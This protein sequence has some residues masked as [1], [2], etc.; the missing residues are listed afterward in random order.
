MTWFTLPPTQ[1]DQ[2]A[3]FLDSR[4]ASAWLAGQPQANA[5]AMLSELLAQLRAFNA[6][7]V[8]PDERFKT[9]TV[10]RNTLSAVS[11]ECQRRYENKPL[12][13]SPAERGLQD[14]VCALWR[15]CAVSYL[16][17]L[18]ACLEGDASISPHA[19]KVAHRA[20]CCLRM[21]QLSCHLGGLPPDGEFWR[22]LHA[23][24]VSAETLG[25]ARD[26][27][28]DRLL[29]ETKELTASGQYAM[30]L[31]LELARPFALSRAQLSTV[32]RWLAR[33]REQARILV[34]PDNSP[35]AC[36]IA[37]DLSLDRPFHDNLRVARL[38]R[39]LSVGPVLRKIGQRI[40]ALAAGETPESLKL[41]PTLSAETCTDLLAELAEHLR[42]PPPGQ[43]L[44]E[45]TSAVEVACGLEN[46]FGVIGGRGLRDASARPS[47]YG[48]QLSQ[49]QLALFGHVVRHEE[50]VGK[51]ETWR[52][53]KG[54]RN[55]VFLLR[56]KGAG[57]ARLALRNLI[58]F[59]AEA[60]APF[61]LAVVRRSFPVQ[62]WRTLHRR[63]CFRRGA[64]AL[65]HGNPRQGERNVVPAP[66]AAVAD[67]ER[68]GPALAFPSRGATGACCVVALP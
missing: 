28:E 68:D 24:L 27:V 56:P 55:E 10:L 15:A 40:E 67:G 58:V 57:E 60:D 61:A 9:L 35:K 29:G 52:V 16:H 54:G 1:A 62:R 4:S 48:S 66:G 2:Q 41:G 65:A 13:L 18:R 30:A 59:Q 33:W 7:R 25:V 64:A 49:A 17:C 42:V 22:T 12:P 44:P 20:L 14:A 21:E 26:L 11:G 31:L 36:C 32:T 3:A 8:A 34:E 37:L 6:C 46:L 43:L 50:K 39:W 63:A 51:T 47:S 45:L 19:A 5:P 23:V 38:A 53:L